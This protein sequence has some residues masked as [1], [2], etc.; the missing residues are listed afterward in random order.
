[1]DKLCY[2]VF[3]ESGL[4]LI[5]VDGIG[6]KIME[7]V[8]KGL[9]RMP[10]W[11]PKGGRKKLA[12][13][14][15]AKMVFCCTGELLGVLRELAEA[16]YIFF[17]VGERM[18]EALGTPLSGERRFIMTEDSLS[19]RV[20][21]SS[22]ENSYIEAVVRLFLTLTSVLAQPCVLNLDLW[23]VREAA[24]KS[25][26]RPA[27]VFWESEFEDIGELI[28]RYQ[29]VLCGNSVLRKDF[30]LLVR[31]DTDLASLNE[32]LEKAVCELGGGYANLA[33]YYEERE[34]KGYE[35]ILILWQ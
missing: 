21:Y 15:T 19:D 20:L 34:I 33:F 18:P 26:G 11:E 22:K 23:D 3:E 17:Y 2:Q 6:L 32:V 30:I 35:G 29:T 7:N 8:N 4:V 25:E 28:S 13:Q 16:N 9:Y 27:V 14:T 1:M 12:E 5:A 10:G 24:E 31:G